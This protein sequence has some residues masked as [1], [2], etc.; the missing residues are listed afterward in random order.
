MDER[1][2]D[3]EAATT[4][5]GAAGAAAT[6]PQWPAPRTGADGKPI[7]DQDFF[8]ALARRGR[9]A[10]NQWRAAHSEGSLQDGTYIRA[11][12]AGV[13]FRVLDN[14]KIDFAGFEFGHG[15]NLSR[16]TFAF[17]AHLLG[18]TF[19]DDADLS[20]ATFDV[21]ADLSDARFGDNANLSAARFA[22]L[23]NLSGASFGHSAN[24][25]DVSFGHI[26]V[27]SGASFGYRANLTGA[28]FGVDT[29]LCGLTEDEWCK[30][31]D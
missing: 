9:D 5:Q 13:D 19:G 10:W 18:A 27:L 21:V 8:L 17:A 6:P 12:F 15:A 25:S 4:G 29:R 28:S 31:C 2:K 30:R 7:Y 23:A 26:V 22:V 24:L 20:G 14:A 1:T 16:A 11:T 3:A